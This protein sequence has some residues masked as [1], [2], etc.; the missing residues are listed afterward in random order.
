MERKNSIGS[1]S[2]PPLHWRGAA[3]A[4]LRIGKAGIILLVVWLAF[5][6]A[7]TPDCVGEPDNPVDKA[8]APLDN[9]VGEVNQKIKDEGPDGDCRLRTTS[10][11]EQRS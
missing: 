3:T 1:L 9:A 6:C 5:G 2:S 4:P 7:N 10:E 8:L 11:I